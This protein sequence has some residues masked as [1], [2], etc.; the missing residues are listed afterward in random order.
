[1]DERFVAVFPSL[2]RTLGSLESAVILQHL[3]FNADEDGDIRITHQQISDE[4]GISER[5][6][7]RRITQLR[8][9]GWITTDRAGAYDATS[10]HR[11]D[12]SRLTEPANLATSGS[13]GGIESAN[14][15]TSDA[16]NLAT[17]SSKKER[18]SSRDSSSAEQLRAR[19]VEPLIHERLT[20]PS[21]WLPSR[22]FTAYLRHTYSDVDLD[23][24]LARFRGYAIDNHKMTRSWENSFESWVA[25]DQRRRQAEA[26]DGG[27]D[28]MGVPRNQNRTSRFVDSRTTEQIEADQAELMRLA[29]QTANRSST[30]EQ[31][32]QP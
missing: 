31:E 7:R 5:T 27:T 1:M 30:V 29:E 26:D 12:H 25:E 6:V 23:T 8:D 2:V 20:L 21:G 18:T 15:A 13:P 14:L 9:E 19:D 32:Q 11:I 17:S 28:D 3:H 16:A 24:S 4:T 10:V 22:E